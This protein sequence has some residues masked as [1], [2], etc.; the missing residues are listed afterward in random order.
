[1]SQ[2]TQRALF[3]YAEEIEVRGITQINA[4]MNEFSGPVLDPKAIKY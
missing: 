2:V 3:D 4:E 1:M